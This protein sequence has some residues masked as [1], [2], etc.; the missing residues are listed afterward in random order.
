MLHPLPTIETLF[1]ENNKVGEHTPQSFESI[2]A[3]NQSETGGL[4]NSFTVAYQWY[5]F[6]VVVNFL[7]CRGLR[8]AC[9]GLQVIFFSFQIKVMPDNW[10]SQKEEVPYLYLSANLWMCSCSLD[11]LRRYL[12]D[13]ELN[14]YVRDGPDI[15]G[16]VESVVSTTNRKKS[17]SNK[18]VKTRRKKENKSVIIFGFERLLSTLETVPKPKPKSVWSLTSC[19]IFADF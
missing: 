13:Y 3:Q 16:D 17:S 11:Y 1:L 7:T 10:F 19:L 5:K 8:L 12:E 9:L 18:E 4:N 2:W 6:T 15:K 14:V